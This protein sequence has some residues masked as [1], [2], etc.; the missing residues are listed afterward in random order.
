MDK[1]T[2]QN[3]FPT[4]LPYFTFEK[5]CLEESVALIV[6]NYIHPH[7]CQDISGNSMESRNPVAEANSKEDPTT[8]FTVTRMA[9]SQSGPR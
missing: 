6:I 5:V 8:M 9:D 3:K 1:K 7:T 4:N 2:V